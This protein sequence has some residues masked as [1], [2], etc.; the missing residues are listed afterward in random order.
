MTKRPGS[1]NSSPPWVADSSSSPAERLRSPAARVLLA[2]ALGSVLFLGGAFL[3]VGRLHSSA[4]DAVEHPSH[5]A[6]DDETKT[7]VIEQ[8]KSL[9]AAARLQQPTAGYLLMSCTNRDDPPYQG[10]VYLTFT[11]PAEARPD[12]YFQTIAAAIVAHGWSAGLPPNQR[13]FGKSLSKDGVTAILY[14]DGDSAN[15]G[16]ARVYGRCRDMNDHRNETTGWVDISSQ[17]H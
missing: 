15:H 10:A 3:A 7:E 1:R 4:A 16:I 2:G 5:T 17:L 14:Q 13:L 9:V 8:T 12:E 11:L 6:T